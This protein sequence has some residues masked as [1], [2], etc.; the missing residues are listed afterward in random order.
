[1][2]RTNWET[3]MDNAIAGWTRGLFLALSLAS[4]SACNIDGDRTSSVTPPAGEQPVTGTPT[5]PSNPPVEPTQPSEEPT[6][7]QEPSE[8]NTPPV[9]PEIPNNP[10]V[11][12][13]EP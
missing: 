11:E 4:I 6:S 7:P 1:M 8:P 12:P 9:E 3:Q 5:E 13:N 2:Y 10:P